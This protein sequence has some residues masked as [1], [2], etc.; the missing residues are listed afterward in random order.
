MNVMFGCWRI[1]C[2]CEERDA[3]Q[4]EQKSL[5]RN[6][7]LNFIANISWAFCCQ[8]SNVEDDG[9]GNG[10]ISVCTTHTIGL[11]KYK[12]SRLRAEIGLVAKQT[13]EKGKKN[14]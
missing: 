14:N 7:Y 2:E 5:S 4:Q 11:T 3:K 10:N 8:P 6:V 12:P 9:N 13:E 1:L